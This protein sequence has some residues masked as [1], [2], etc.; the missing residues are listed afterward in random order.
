MPSLSL[1]FP[2]S[3]LK[4]GIIWGF[5]QK[6]YFLTIWFI[7]KYNLVMLVY[8]SLVF[9]RLVVLLLEVWESQIQIS[10]GNFTKK[11]YKKYS[12]GECYLTNQRFGLKEN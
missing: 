9:I 8:N 6:A 11:D 3:S 12:L 1:H 5:Q 10:I 7:D 2:P 4:E